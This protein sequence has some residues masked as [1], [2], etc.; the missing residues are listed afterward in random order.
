MDALVSEDNDTSW[1][2]KCNVES[3]LK[4]FY[5]CCQVFAEWDRQGGLR[6]LVVMDVLDCL[7]AV[8]ATLAMCLSTGL[9]AAYVTVVWVVVPASQC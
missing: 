3:F 9:L 2:V 5:V 4:R 7:C 1:C 6:L 8:R